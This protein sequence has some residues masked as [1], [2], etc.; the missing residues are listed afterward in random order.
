MSVEPATMSN[1]CLEVV[2]G[3]HKSKIPLGEDRCI[4]PAWCED[5]EWLPVELE[6]GEFLVFGSH[7]AH[8]SGPNNSDLGR[9]AIYATY[10]AD[11]G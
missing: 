9:A 7:L 6:T 11:S 4:T 10:N 3:S 2:A 8:R 5:H 1:G